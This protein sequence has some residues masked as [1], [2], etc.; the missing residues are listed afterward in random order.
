MKKL[1]ILNLPIYK[2]R[3]K[4]IKENTQI[5]DVVRKKYLILTAEE[6]VRQNFIHYLYK[7]KKYPLGLMRVEQ[8]VR[9][10]DMRKRAD[11]VLYN[12]EGNPRMIVECKSLEIDITQETFYQIAKY[13]SQL[14][15][16]FLVLTNGL[17]HFCCKIDYLNNQ[18]DFLDKI[19]GYESVA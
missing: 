4:V 12:T 15:V 14:H 6:W 11:I 9:Y 1:P 17:H 18:I 8:I 7:E 5:F 16:D 2:L 19:P 10:N 3:T 13:N